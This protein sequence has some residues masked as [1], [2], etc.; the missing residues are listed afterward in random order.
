MSTETRSRIRTP[1]AAALDLPPPFRLVTLRE[2]G[3][4]FAHA[5]AIASEAGAGTL[6]WVGRFDLVEF[7]LVVEPDE[8]LKAARRTFY[9]A[10]AALA[11]ALLVHAPPEK[12]IAFDWP[13]AVFVDGGLIGGARLA[14]PEGAAEDEPPP[15]L[16]F[17]AMIRT[18]TTA[19]GDPGLRPFAARREEEGFN[20]LGSGRLVEGFAR[21][22][23]VVL[24]T[25][26]ESG[27]PAV[28]KSYLQWLP[29]ES[30][31]RREIDENGDLLLRRT[32]K[33]R[34]ERR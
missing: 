26:R 33:A 5:T 11:D 15:W 7:A 32:G 17:G 14:W 13:D 9:A 34:V 21:H 8:P 20:V 28:A 22:F 1:Y 24:D 23:M 12:L 27:F 3:D 6:V 18:V 25:W 2:V 16:V 29:T 30:G 19:S 10:M 31:L 4:A